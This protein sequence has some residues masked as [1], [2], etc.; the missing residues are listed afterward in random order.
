MLGTVF[1]I[2]NC[3]LVY[4]L[5]AGTISAYLTGSAVFQF[6]LV[7]GIFM[8]AMGFGA[9]LSRFIEEDLFDAFISVELGA[10]V[11][12]GFSAL[13]LYLAFIYLNHYALVLYG[14]C[15]MVGTFIG[16]EIP[17]VLRLLE[18]ELS[19][20]LNVSAV[21]GLDYVGALTASIA[22]PIVLLPYLGQMA[23]A[24]MFGLL[25][26]SVAILCAW[27]FRDRLTTP[28]MTFLKSGTAGVLLLIG[29][30]FS[31]TLVSAFEAKLFTD[32]IVLSET[33]PH[34]RI[35]MTRW[36]EDL[37]LYLNGNL[38]FSTLDEHRYHE[39][40]VHTAMGFSGSRKKVLILG[41]GDGMAAR[42]VLKYDDVERVDLVELDERVTDLFSKNPQLTDLNGGSLNDARVHIH[43]R[44][45][46]KFLEE[47]SAERQYDR[48]IADFPDPNNPGIGK[49]YSVEFYRM[50]FRHLSGEGVFITQATSAY[51]SP[52]AFR[53]IEKS[54]AKAPHPRT[55]QPVD[56]R[57]IHAYVPSLGD[58]G[59]VLAAPRKVDR[60]DWSLEV[61]SDYLN[62]EQFAAH[63]VFPKD[64]A[65]RPV[66]A[67]HLDNQV[68]VRYYERDWQDATP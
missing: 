23:T 44:D 13:I 1:L 20:K 2:A 38:Q 10:G 43:N 35:V 32:T 60:K 5:L 68:L 51:R 50:L 33:T 39:T 34:Q 63:F 4:E 6:S 24:F 53:C 64:R 28:K 45:A 56:V 66:E 31:G 61:E 52:T 55:R 41:G 22:F 62:P 46:F 49:V 17:L 65:G 18:D 54:I 30:T 27:V 12:G 8:A 15:G 58:W 37:R 29:L 59:F 57:P 21:L 7:V 67:N 9:Y 3:G 40:L 19:L 48:I 26:V 16:M 25:N 36:R 42:E 11:V 47:M 14:V